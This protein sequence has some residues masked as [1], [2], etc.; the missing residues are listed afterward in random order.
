MSNIQQLFFFICSFFN[1]QIPKRKK[2][3]LVFPPHNY[4]TSWL[5]VRLHDMSHHHHPSVTPSPSP[6]WDAFLG[7]NNFTDQS[8]SPCSHSDHLYGNLFLSSP[9]CFQQNVPVQNVKCV[10]RDVKVKYCRLFPAIIMS[11]LVLYPTTCHY[12]QIMVVSVKNEAFLWFYISC[13]LLEI[14]Q[15]WSEMVD[16]VFVCVS[17]SQGE[18]GEPGQKGS[19][20]D[21]GEQVRYGKQCPII[22]VS[23]T[24][25]NPLF[26]VIKESLMCFAYASQ[27]DVRL[28]LLVCDHSGM[29]CD[30]CFFFFLMFRVLPAQLVS[31]VPLVPQVLL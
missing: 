26:A 28:L 1:L 9:N 7:L 19:K 12:V 3:L 2:K 20:A 16:C 5:N 11:L 27:S 25:F 29:L 15:S 23:R 6:D 14:K 24:N 4:V 31:K 13:W 18:V 21:K 10:R 8:S 30:Q 17:L 22:P